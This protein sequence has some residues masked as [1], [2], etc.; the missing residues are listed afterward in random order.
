MSE[1]YPL[2]FKTIFKEKIWGGQKI[3]TILNKDY[4]DLDNCGETWELSGVDGNI[5]Q[6]LN[7]SLAGQKITDLIQSNKGAL[8]GEKVYAQFG[9]E[10]PLLIK[11]I[12]AAQDLS[13][14]V[15]PDDKMA[16]ERHNGFGKT[17]MWYILQADENASLISGFNKE[18]NKDEYLEHFSSGK[19]TDILNREEAKKHDVFFLPAG[20]VHTIGA[21]LMLAEIQQTSDITYRIYDFDRIDKNGNKREL[22]VDEALD[23]IDFKHYP[24]YKT[25]FADK[26]NENNSII[27]TPFF[28][29]NK[30]T[31]DKKMSLDKSDLDCFKIYIG[32]GG[33]GKIAG[34]S[35]QF[36]EVLLV[37]AAMKTYIIEPEGELELLETYID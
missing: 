23:A 20:R 21:G 11:F 19:L 28:T 30:L 18:T 10:F 32:V 8:V 4:G 25:R 24:N 31:L 2:K 7:G 16:K 34:E 29:T 12:D 14:Q 33:R 26:Q 3:K 36:G 37:P 15:H 9:D 35:I 5:S 13:I 1:I 22:H 27:S 17:E 6:V